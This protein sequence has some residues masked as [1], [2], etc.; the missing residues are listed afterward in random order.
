MNYAALASIDV[1]LTNMDNDIAALVLTAGMGCAAAGGTITCDT[2]NLGTATFSVRLATQPTAT[3]TVAMTSAP[4]GEGVAAPLMLAFN[5]T[6]WNMPLP[7]T[8]TGLDAAPAMSTTYTVTASAS[9]GGYSNVPPST[10]M[11]VNNPATLPPPP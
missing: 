5:S 7:V 9:G 6:T 2:S 10:V 8:L 11:C 4:V 3:V 1:N